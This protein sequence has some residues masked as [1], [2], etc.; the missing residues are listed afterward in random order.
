[1]VKM[2][3]MSDEDMSA[4]GVKSR[5]WTQKQFGFDQF[6]QRWDDLFTHIHEEKGSWDTRSGYTK[7]EVRTF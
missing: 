3:E 4:L 1:M 6:V 7:Y 2:F 5:E